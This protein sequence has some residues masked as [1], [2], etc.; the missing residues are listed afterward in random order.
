MLHYPDLG[1]TMPHHPN[2]F[3]KEHYLCGIKNQHTFLFMIRITEYYSIWLLSQRW[4]DESRVG[5][6]VDN[7]TGV[8]N[9]VKFWHDSFYKVMCSFPHFHV[10]YKFS[11]SK[12]ASYWEVL[13]NILLVTKITSQT[14]SVWNV[15]KEWLWWP[16]TSK[17]CIYLHWLDQLM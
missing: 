3:S 5:G 4:V 14:G 11:Y 16:H 15:W 6:A 7:F 8:T 1:L 13:F 10:K 9:A 2:H 12:Q 17:R